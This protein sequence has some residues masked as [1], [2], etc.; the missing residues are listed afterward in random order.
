M[1]CEGSYVQRVLTSI[2][3]METFK[4]LFHEYRTKYSVPKPARW[5]EK[6]YRGA[7]NENGI[8][9]HNKTQVVIDGTT[10]Y[11]VTVIYGLKDVLNAS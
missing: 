9:V 7:F 8:T 11:N 2:I 3:L 5:T 4:E 10:Y 1:I 6:V